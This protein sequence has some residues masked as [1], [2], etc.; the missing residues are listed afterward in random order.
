M[1][2]REIMTT[3]EGRGHRGHDDQVSSDRDRGER[4]G[5]RKG[6]RDAKSEEWSVGSDDES[7]EETDK[8]RMPV[9][10]LERSEDTLTA[11]PWGT[12]E[13]SAGGPQ[14]GTRAGG[15][16]TRKA[17]SAAADEAGMQGRHRERPAQRGR[18]GGRQEKHA[19][20]TS[21]VQGNNEGRQASRV[22]NKSPE[23]GTRRGALRPPEWLKTPVGDATE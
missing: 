19:G 14:V 1:A 10:E 20:K 3:E 15:S 9:G 23:W 11:S 4:H 5:A 16:N 21:G 18:Q 12:Q 17:P 13:I 22:P 8:E 7:D 6:D 2:V